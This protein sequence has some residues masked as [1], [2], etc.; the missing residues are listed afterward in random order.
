M[1]KPDTSKNNAS[2]SDYAD[3]RGKRQIQPNTSDPK[4]SRP[5][6]QPI[7]LGTLTFAS[8]PVQSTV[9]AAGSASALPATPTG[10][11]QLNIG[12]STSNYVIPFYKAS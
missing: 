3:E 7:I 6:I 2:Q 1:D 11:L 12:G 5:M 4:Q 8:N 9:G 10:Y